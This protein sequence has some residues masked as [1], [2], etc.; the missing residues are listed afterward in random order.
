MVAVQSDGLTLRF[1]SVELRDDREIVLTAVAQNSNALEAASEALRDD[2]AVVLA[3]AN[4]SPCNTLHSFHDYYGCFG[5]SFGDPFGVNGYYHQKYQE[6]QDS[7]FMSQYGIPT[8]GNLH[9]A[10]KRLRGMKEI[11]L[12][13]VERDWS[14]LKYASAEMQDDYDVVMGAHACPLFLHLLLLLRPP[15]EASA[16][17]DFVCEILTGVLCLVC[18]I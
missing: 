11:A 10:S 2:A 12:P 13:A 8:R 1:A 17:S 16:L 5:N 3:A 4:S 14:M 6:S 7:P 15:L 9:Y 18:Y